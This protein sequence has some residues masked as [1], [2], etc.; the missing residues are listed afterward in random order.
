MQKQLTTQEIDSI[1]RDIEIPNGRFR[2]GLMFTAGREAQE[3]FFIQVVCMLPD[4]LDPT[5][6]VTE[7]PGRKW[8][9]SSFSTHNEVVQSCLYAWLKYMEHEARESFKY[10]GVR[11]FNPHISV[12][13][14]MSVADQTEVRS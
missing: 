3:G 1:C 4:V 6:P 7:Q 11:L 2:W 14:L 12:S 9:V 10:Q 8:Y 13:A 5:G